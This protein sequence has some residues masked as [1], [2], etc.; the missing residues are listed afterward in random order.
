MQY[1]PP[2]EHAT[3]LASYGV[4]SEESDG[5]RLQATLRMHPPMV[6]Q[7]QRVKYRYSL[8][9]REHPSDTGEVLLYITSEINMLAHQGSQPGGSHFLCVFDEIGHHNL[10]S[11]NDWGEL[12]PF[13]KRAFEIARERLGID[14]DALY[15]WAASDPTVEP[16]EPVDRFIMDTSTSILLELRELWESSGA[17]P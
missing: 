1:E 5:K 11:S 4:E 7:P 14:L 9:L 15:P 8:E 2:I 12:I 6:D 13:T 16:A 3:V 10:G 17:E